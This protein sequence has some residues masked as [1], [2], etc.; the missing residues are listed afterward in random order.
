MAN[1]LILN[2][3]A[4]LEDP[5]SGVVELGSGT[6]LVGMVVHQLSREKRVWLTDGNAEVVSR[7]RAN[8]ALNGQDEEGHVSV[9]QLDWNLPVTT[10]LDVGPAPLVLGADVIYDPELVPGLV[11]TVCHLLSAGA[12]GGRGGGRPQALVC[13][14]VRAPA[15][16][17]AFLS[18]CRLAKL[19]VQF[20]DVRPA[21]D[22]GRPDADGIL[23]PQAL[24][25]TLA[26]TPD[27]FRLVRLTV[28]GAA[29]P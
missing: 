10:P 6:G 26:Y 4:L 16:W 7:L 24:D 27:N 12:D 17:E 18:T 2:R 19:Q 28:A 21:L 15:T 1:H 20:L 9:R 22:A 13:A 5:D 29:R 3:S 25:A 23:F 14:L 11:R 8:V